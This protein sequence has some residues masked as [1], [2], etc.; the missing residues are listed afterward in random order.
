MLE[1]VSRLTGYPTEMLGMDMDIESDL[2]I[3]SIKRVEILSTL[4]EQIPNLPAI[5]PEI[6]GSLKTL[7]QIVEYLAATPDSEVLPPFPE[8][9]DAESS[10][11]TH[12][13]I[14]NRMLETVSRLTGY[15]TEML[16]M[17]MDIESDLG[18]DSIKRV[19]ILSTLEEQIP[20]LPAISPEIMGSL[21]TLGQIVEYLAG[22]ETPQI[23]E[24]HTS[25]AS[26]D[27]H[28]DTVPEPPPPLFSDEPDGSS[29]HLAGQIGRKVVSV[30]EQPFVQ[31][32]RLALPANHKVF[33]T[34]D[35]TGLSEAIAHEFSSRN[36]DAVILSKQMISDIVTGQ[37]VGKERCRTGHGG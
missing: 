31:N 7:G 15:P 1:T 8:T 25:P 12:Q 2:G 16:G 18:I 22:A 32:V 24:S 29:Q 11:N 9:K 17:D 21:K 4:E 33:I 26:Q 34:D 14:E 35:E 36:I 27:S 3:D 5:S 20:N 13:E 28:T 37:N 6:M 23:P 10:T 30:V 19:E